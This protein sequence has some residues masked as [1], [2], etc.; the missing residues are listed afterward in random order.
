MKTVVVG[1]KGLIG[2]KLVQELQKR[3]HDVAS[4]SRKTGVD[5]VTG[6]GLGK[7]LAGT[8]VVI[9]VT[10]APTWEDAAVLNFFETASKNLLAVESA[11]GVKHHIALSVVGTERLL[12]SGYFRAKIAQEKLI[13]A[14]Q[15]P[16]TIVRATQFFEFVEGIAQLST[17]GKVVRLPPAL[18][19]PMASKDVAS[20]LAEVAEGKPANGMVEVAGPESIRLDELVRRF[21]KAK[22]D[23]RQVTTDPAALYYGIKVDD[24]S[25]T[26]GANPRLGAMRFDDWLATSSSESAPVR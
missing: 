1:G 24:R 14:S 17:E 26:P 2:T 16:Y 25:L 5:L 6:E 12:S 13:A 8:Q 15:I 11:A 9:D 19:Q 7:A 21:L 22:N 18:M 4:A 20:A 10:N 3:G 23:P